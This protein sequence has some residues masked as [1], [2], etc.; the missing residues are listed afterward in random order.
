MSYSA[1]YAPSKTS[2]SP[3]QDGEGSVGYSYKTSPYYTPFSCSGG[4]QHP[5]G[6]SAH[7]A[8]TAGVL[9]ASPLQSYYDPQLFGNYL[10]SSPVPALDADL[11]Q[12]GFM[13]ESC[14]EH[15][16]PSAQPY[17]VAE[18]Y[19]NYDMAFKPSPPEYLSSA[20]AGAK[21]SSVPESTYSSIA[22]AFGGFPAPRLGRAS[23]NRVSDPIPP[24][25][26]AEYNANN[27]GTG[28]TSHVA[29]SPAGQAAT[30]GHSLT[31]LPDASSGIPP[32][33]PQR[34]AF[35]PRR[36]ATV[37]SASP[38]PS[39]DPLNRWKCP[40]CT[41]VQDTKRGPDLR[42]HIETHTRPPPGETDKANWVCCGIP[43]GVAEEVGVPK[44]VREM[45]SFKYQGM[46]FVG[47]C[48]K[49]FSRKDALARHLRQREGACFGDSRAPY[50]LGN[51]T[52]AA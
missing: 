27:D 8:A 24:M 14:S 9:N 10:A 51:K 6:T 41:W 11:G 29:Q 17:F 35:C 7:T 20:S 26:T 28:G 12:D 33:R 22:G 3:P 30:P 43:A 39:V 16:A 34:F 40:Y 45:T 42:R 18:Y 32:Q 37:S 15:T 1:A 49:V 52:G 50:L 21:P 23:Q 2:R 38:A 5:L 31:T 13:S 44:E 47:G 4:A 25:Q 46:L 19:P 48:E 36:N